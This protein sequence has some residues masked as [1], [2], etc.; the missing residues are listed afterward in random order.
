MI[1]CFI[2]MLLNLEECRSSQEKEF[3]LRNIVHNDILRE[4]LCLLNDLFGT[5]VI[6]FCVS[7]LVKIL[8]ILMIV[9]YNFKTRKNLVIL[10]KEQ[11]EE[12]SSTKLA[13][14][15]TNKR[16]SFERMI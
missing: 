14:A 5:E 13:I 4:H 9:V 7:Y 2:S 6:Y 11:P 8:F 15:S 10:I 16:A 12:A 1:S 3:A